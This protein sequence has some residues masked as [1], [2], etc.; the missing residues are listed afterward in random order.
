M[1]FNWDVENVCIV[2]PSWRVT[3]WGTFLLSLIGVMALTACY[4]GVR[5]LSRRYEASSSEYLNA[6]PSMLPLPHPPSVSATMPGACSKT[7]A[8]PTTMRTHAHGLG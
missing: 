6:L 1:L 2:F 4:E 3:G 8:K 5:E 7:C